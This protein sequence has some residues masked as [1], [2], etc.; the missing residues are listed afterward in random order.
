MRVDG[1]PQPPFR[2]HALHHS[3]ATHLLATGADLRT[4]Q[5]LLGHASVSS[6]QIYTEVDAAR[7]STSIA[8]RTLEPKQKF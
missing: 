8:T 1:A 5:E 3:L 6:T 2:P 7:R 4:L